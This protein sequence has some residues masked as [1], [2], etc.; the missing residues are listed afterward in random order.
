MDESR[1]GHPLKIDTIE[2]PAELLLALEKSR[3]RLQ[4]TTPYAVYNVLWLWSNSYCGVFGDGPNGSY[5]WFLWDGSKL[6]T[7]NCGYGSPNWALRDVLN[8]IE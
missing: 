3:D 4:Y 2:P 5:E 7:S 1:R 6:E 8:K